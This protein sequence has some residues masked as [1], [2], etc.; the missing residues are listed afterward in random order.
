MADDSVKGTNP[1]YAAQLG[2]PMKSE[3]DKTIKA[4]LIEPDE[5][6]LNEMYKYVLTT[7]QEQ[8]VYIPI[9]YQALLSVYRTGELKGVKFMPEENRIPV[10]TTV[11]VK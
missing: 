10:W 9:S 11:K 8:A 6:K 2:L 4:L 5:T 7:L 1:A 3:L